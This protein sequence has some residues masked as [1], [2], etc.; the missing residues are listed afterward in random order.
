MKINSW[1]YQ[2]M[3]LHELSNLAQRC[4]HAKIN[5]H[6]KIFTSTVFLELFL[7]IHDSKINYLNEDKKT[8]MCQNTYLGMVSLLS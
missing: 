4:T 2:L 1:F 5:L 3:L 8:Y 7:G 6:Y